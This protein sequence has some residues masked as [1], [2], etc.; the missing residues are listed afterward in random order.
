MSAL[1][2]FRAPENKATSSADPEISVV[3]PA[4]ACDDPL[5]LLRDAIAQLKSSN[6]DLPDQA[7][8]A[9]LLTE[10][11]E[12]LERAN[13]IGA[14]VARCEACLKEGEFEK[15]FASL[16]E[17]LTVYPG[18]L[19][20][21]ARRRQVEEQQKAFHS[22]A[23][24]RG[25][26]EEA[27]WLLD[28]DRTD[29]AAHLLKEKAAQLPDQAELTSRLQELEALLPY[30][31][32][33]RY[34]QAALARAAALEHAQQWQAAL[35]ILEESL[36]TYSANADLIA[37]ANRVRSQLRDH[38][39][40]KK[41]A[42]RVELISQQIKACSWRQALA[43]LENTQLEFRDAGE[44]NPLRRQIVDGLR[45]SECEDVVAEVQ[46]YLADS[47]LE[48]AELALSRG[49]SALGPEPVLDALR[50]ELETERKYR[51]ELRTAQVLFG[52]HQLQE[53]ER[54]LMQL[55]PLGRPEAQAL[56]DAVRKER[57]AS[58]EE[59]FFE[60]G[61]DKAL[62]L[63]Q[64]KQ[65]AQA[66]DL[67]RNLL[68][69][70]P[71]NPILERDLTVAQSGLELAAPTA[72]PAQA[73][74]DEYP[75]AEVRLPA[76]PAAAT[77]AREKT[78]RR[79]RRTIAGAASLLL[80]S[81]TGVA[82]KMSRPAAPVSKPAAAPAAPRP[83]V[84]TQSSVAPTPEPAAAAP[85]S[86]TPVQPAAAPTVQTGRP[87]STVAKAQPAPPH[88]IPLRPFVSP[89]KQT[90]GQLPNS[91]LPLPPATEPAVSAQNIS[92]LPVSLTR[93]VNL[94]APP[95]PAA[96]QDVPVTANPKPVPPPG[97]RFAPAELISRT[98]PAIPEMA[99]QRAVYGL[100]KID[101]VIDE[102]GAVKSVKVVSGDPILAAA[103]K[104]AVLKW[105]YKP[106]TLNDRPIA[107]AA[108]I[109]ITF[110]DRK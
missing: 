77:A 78:P 72:A 85:E 97:G 46:R 91:A 15:A 50:E 60:R 73:K 106:A 33:K 24:V 98:L 103:A 18:D 96:P 2:Q 28:Q 101:A 25:A 68:S 90:A 109:Q 83:P 12:A 9:N 52:R 3:A 70:F 51:D 29:L 14:A 42:R 107:S 26:L 31:E 16:D 94:P 88:T 58:E 81:A 5:Q 62:E 67:L 59:N 49:F 69:L 8:V 6:G 22:A 61:R 47:E 86:K 89:A 110:S 17:G 66:V 55:G 76:G 102:Y 10:A 48:R 71:G 23:A 35:T 43:L 13:V 54:V 41:L 92:G 82:W 1:R 108:V 87:A 63:I 32:Q 93:S 74:I 30:W 21:V 34:V 99:R 39:R 27:K 37:A 45:R 44:L 57:A 84:V 40:Q 104:T 11:R 20:L 64:Q 65:F 79:F 75:P 95:R 80:V 19:V 53:A 56:L 4:P 7:Q 36:Q 105:K 100:V 38:E